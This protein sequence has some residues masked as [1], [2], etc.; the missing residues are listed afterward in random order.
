[1]DQMKTVKFLTYWIVNSVGLL[2]ASLVFRNYIV[3]GNSKIATTLAAVVCALL[4][5]VWG[6]FVPVI[7]KRM[8]IAVKDQ[9]LWGL[10]YLISN[11]IIVWVLKY[12]ALYLGL[13]VSSIFFTIVLGAA[14]TGLQWI[15]ASAL[16]E[17]K[18]EK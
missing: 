9:K 3:L 7:L 4:I 5:T 10:I 15:A 6:Y 12:L 13:G 18:P 1:M 2:A 17:T 16:G 14:L 11:V 8:G